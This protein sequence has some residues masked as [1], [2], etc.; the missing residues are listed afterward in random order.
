MECFKSARRCHGTWEADRIR[1]DRYDAARSA[2]TSLIYLIV[3]QTTH[4]AACFEVM[5]W[6]E[7]AKRNEKQDNCSCILEDLIEIEKGCPAI[8]RVADDTVMVGKSRWVLWD[9]TSSR[10]ALVSN[11]P[12]ACA[13]EE[14]FEGRYRRAR[15][16]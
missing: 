4:L 13:I 1:I 5:L 10:S 6:G 15:G 2:P 12:L 9:S 16:L 11:L 8:G 14:G 3:P 7:K